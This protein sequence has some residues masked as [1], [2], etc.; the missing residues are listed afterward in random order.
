MS[1]KVIVLASFVACG[2]LSANAFGVDEK[3]NSKKPD[4]VTATREA[5]EGFKQVEFFAAMDAGQINVRLRMEDSTEGKFIIENKTDEP[6][7]IRCQK[8]LP[9]FL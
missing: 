6:I 1:R 8:P 3:T 9:A 7:S 5:A 4:R 2:I